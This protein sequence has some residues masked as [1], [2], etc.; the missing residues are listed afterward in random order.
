MGSLTLRGLK[1][2]VVDGR[3]IQFHSDPLVADR[4]FCKDAVPVC[5]TEGSETFKVAEF[6][7]STKSWD[8]SK[9]S[10]FY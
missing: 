3:S 2:P 1:W 10:L 4:P 6:I 8:L 9:L 5:V 7:L